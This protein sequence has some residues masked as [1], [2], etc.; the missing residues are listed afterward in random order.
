[1]LLEAPAA[2]GNTFVAD[3]GVDCGVSMGVRHVTVPA[4]IQ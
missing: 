3:L 2:F 1:M 4:N